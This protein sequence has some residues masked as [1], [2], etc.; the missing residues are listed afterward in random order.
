M[1][2]RIQYEIDIVTC[3]GSNIEQVLLKEHAVNN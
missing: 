1:L 3:E 2:F